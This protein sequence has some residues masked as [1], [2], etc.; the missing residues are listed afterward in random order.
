MNEVYVSVMLTAVIEYGAGWT[1]KTLPCLRYV[2]LYWD[3]E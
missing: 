3:V 2:T 1:P